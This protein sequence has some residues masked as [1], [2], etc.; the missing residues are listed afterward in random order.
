MDR[1]Y[2]HSIVERY[3]SGRDCGIHPLSCGH[4]CEVYRVDLCDQQFI[5][6]VRPEVFSREHLQAD[7]LLLGYL[8]DHGFPSPSVVCTPAGDS[9]LA[10]PDGRLCELLEYIPHDSTLGDS[11]ALWMSGSVAALL[12]QFHRLTRRY[13]RII[14]KPDYVGN[15]PVNPESK[16][17]RGPLERGVPRYERGAGGELRGVVGRLRARLLQLHRLM[18]SLDLSSQVVNH[19]DFY[20]DNLLTSGS[21]LVGVIDFDFCLTGS[22][23]IDLTEGLYASMIYSSRAAPFWGL[24]PARGI[25]WTAGAE[26]LRIYEEESGLVA[27][28]PLLL[29]MLEVKVISLVFYPGFILA[30]SPAKRLKT[31]LRAERITAALGDGR[32]QLL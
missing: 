23:L 19:N 15:T 2:V 21:E 6:R 5:L 10:T 24:D 3:L 7:H 14:C 9:Y 18:P 22:H 1:T 32:L 31:L 20:G 27:S 29:S 30:D 11:D 25:D 13:P 28:R 12:G 8:S 4:I 26:F 17:F 16:Y